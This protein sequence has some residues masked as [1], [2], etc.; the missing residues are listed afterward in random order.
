[1]KRKFRIPP[2]YTFIVGSSNPSRIVSLAPFV[3]SC[4]SPLSQQ[5]DFRSTSTNSSSSSSGSSC[6]DSDVDDEIYQTPPS[7]ADSGIESFDMNPF[8]K[9]ARQQNQQVHF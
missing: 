5:R 4:S 9:L 8:E 2:S 3:S 1:M 6:L 7:S